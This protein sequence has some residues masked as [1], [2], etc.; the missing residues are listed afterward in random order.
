MRAV[1][2][3]LSLL[4]NVVIHYQRPHFKRTMFVQVQLGDLS[5]L[6]IITS[7]SVLEFRTTSRRQDLSLHT[8]SLIANEIT[9]EGLV[10][11][12]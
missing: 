9:R 7:S 12:Y 5:R 1:L 4:P 8:A 6:V 2:I 10:D 11:P 3:L